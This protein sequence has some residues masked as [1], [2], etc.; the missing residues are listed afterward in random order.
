MARPASSGGK[1][2]V[3]WTL[4]ALTQSA[5]ITAA[6]LAL[7]LATSLISFSVIQ[8][9]LAEALTALAALFPS[10]IPGL[11]AG[12]LLAN[13]LN[14]SPL[15]PIDVLAGSATTLAAAVLTWYLARPWRRHLAEQVAG[16]KSGKE[17]KGVRLAAIR[18]LP[19]LPPLILN[20]LVVGSYL[21][22]LVAGRQVTFL[23]VAGSVASILVSQALVVLGLGLPLAMALAKTPWAQRVYLAEQEKERRWH[24]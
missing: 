20:A 13:L 21:P 7:T 5:L 8:L 16:G 2:P 11:F 12:C 14:P 9:R 19:L 17:D 1:S 10:A 6:Y 18:I 23:M 24:S 3:S 22:F 4:A 15:G